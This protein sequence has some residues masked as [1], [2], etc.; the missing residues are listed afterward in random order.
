MEWNGMV[1]FNL[2]SLEAIW[3]GALLL[4]VYRHWFSESQAQSIR[5]HKLQFIKIKY[6]HKSRAHI[7]VIIHFGLKWWKQFHMKCP[8]DEY[9]IIHVIESMMISLHYELKIRITD[10]LANDEHTQFAKSVSINFPHSIFE[11][12]SKISSLSNG[13]EASLA[14]LR[15][16]S[17]EQILLI[18][19]ND[20]PLNALMTF[21]NFGFN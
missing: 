7:N 4:N 15:C 6:I 11:S 12:L 1:W 19:L 16:F 5:M 18:P 17:V 20:E 13:I 2:K 8:W 3:L 14:S 9:W 21:D 10:H